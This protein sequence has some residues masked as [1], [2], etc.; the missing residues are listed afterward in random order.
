MKHAGDTQKGLIANQPRLMS[1]FESIHLPR[2]H[3]NRKQEKLRFRKNLS[4]YVRY[5]QASPSVCTRYSV[6]LLTVHRNNINAISTDACLPRNSTPALTAAG[7]SNSASSP[8]SSSRSY[9]FGRRIPPT[10][11]PSSLDT[12][13]SFWFKATIP[14]PQ[15][16][17]DRMI[18]RR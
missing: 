17:C 13:R 6:C 7:S 10:A 15:L 4:T 14:A 12:F 8:S 3:R 1:T 9:A 5:V 18:S 11:C 16:S 2:L